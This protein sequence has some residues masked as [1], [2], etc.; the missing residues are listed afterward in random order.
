VSFFPGRKIVRMRRETFLCFA[1][2]SAK[3]EGFKREIAVETNDEGFEM[4]CDLK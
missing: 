3:V 2:D 4:K 1:R